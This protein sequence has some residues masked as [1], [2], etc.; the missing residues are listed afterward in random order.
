MIPASDP[1]GLLLAVLLVAGHVFAD[2][3]FQTGAMARGKSRFPLLLAHLMIVFAT[4][5]ITLLPLLSLRIVAVLA[6]V[7]LFHGALDGAKAALVARRRNRALEWF[8]LDQTLH[9][10][11]LAAAWIL[12]RP[13]L[14]A[15][16]F[17]GLLAALPCPPSA[18]ATATVLVAAY[19]FNFHGA[20]A[21]VVAVLERFHLSGEEPDP[22]GGEAPA[23]AAAADRPARGRAIGIL[24]RWMV[25]TLVLS[26]QWGA[27][28]LL[29]AAK[30]VA[31]FRE[32]ENRE[33]SE[34]YLI[35]TLTSVLIAVASALVVDAARRAL[36]AI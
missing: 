3:A 16:F 10:A 21:V 32:L 36:G 11:S 15:P 31:R 25:L 8:L 7:T 20:S 5:A 26:G 17:P 35:G 22:A 23:A 13:D 29:L 1:V 28:G 19:V 18:L 30:S 33:L 27:L 9:V 12:L 2:F 6:G 34:Y 4:H 24:E 14:G